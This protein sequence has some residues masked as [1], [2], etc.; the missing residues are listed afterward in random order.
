MWEVGCTG[1]G[2]RIKLLIEL[3]TGP[4]RKVNLLIEILT[5]MRSMFCCFQRDKL[6]GVTIL[7]VDFVV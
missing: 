4:C 7:L 3:L 2:R 1:P 6:G 5:H